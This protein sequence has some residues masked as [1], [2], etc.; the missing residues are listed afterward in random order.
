MMPVLLLLPVQL[1]PAP[2]SERHNQVLSMRT[3]LLLIVKQLLAV[4][5]SAPPILQCTS[6]KALGFLEWSAELPIGPT[7]NNVG[8]LVGPASIMSP[9]NVTPSTSAT[10]MAG[11][12]LSGMS[13]G[14]PSPSTIVSGF[15]I[16]MLS[17]KW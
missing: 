9:A 7:C 15:E 1:T 8:E 4:P 6:N 11:I 13:V 17:A 5:A 14:I 12:P 2:S 16:W 3:W 10:T